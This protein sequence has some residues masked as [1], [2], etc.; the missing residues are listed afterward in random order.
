[1]RCTSLGTRVCRQRKSEILGRVQEG[2][3]ALKMKIHS[4][5]EKR[6]FSCMSTRT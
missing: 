6:G 2:G 4:T 3:L 5:Q 1:M